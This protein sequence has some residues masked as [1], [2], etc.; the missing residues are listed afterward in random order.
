M[1]L[2]FLAPRY[3]H[4]AHSFSTAGLDIPR[5]CCSGR[6][7]RR[8]N[9]Q[10]TLKGR[11]HEEEGLCEVPCHSVNQKRKYDHVTFIN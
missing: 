6:D 4:V 11:G 9:S 5:R 7:G 3:T 2:L 10:V 8:K 1:Y